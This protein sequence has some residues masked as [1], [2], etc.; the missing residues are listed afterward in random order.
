V[1]VQRAQRVGPSAM[2]DAFMDVFSNVLKMTNLAAHVSG[3]RAFVRPW[4]IHV[5]AQA[6][7]IVHIVKR[8]VCW[9]RRGDEI[10]PLSSGELV[11]LAHGDAHTLAS[12]RAMLDLQ[13]SR[14]EIVK[15]RALPSSRS[16]SSSL[17]ETTEIV[18]ATYEL[19]QEAAHPLL[20]LLPPVIHFSRAPEDSHDELALLVQLILKES[21]RRAI[22]TDA[23]L[24]HL[25]ETLFVYIVR[26]WLR[27]Q[28]SE[29]A[30]WIGALRDPQIR[31]ALTSIHNA[32]HVPWSVESLARS[33]A[34]SRAAFAKRFSELVGEPPLTYLTRWRM[35]LAAKLLR[36]SN[37]PVARIAARVGYIS[38]TAFAKAFKRWRKSA[39]GQY[40]R[41]R[42]PTHL[43]SSKR[44]TEVAA[45]ALF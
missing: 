14:N 33:V 35:D 41:L 34:M 21:E 16:L 5:E 19:S 23:V 17:T 1:S 24:P 31:R 3:A 29:T 10:L 7:A 18:S 45:D 20:L 27:K 37:E 39:P 26:S 13:S 2:R 4:G 11:L 43:R 9:L 15:S 36:E 30:G 42:N 12:D 40:R 8:G 25:V 22:G 28:P 38:E 6:H 44:Q 32:P